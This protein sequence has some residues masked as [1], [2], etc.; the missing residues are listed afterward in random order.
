MSGLHIDLYLESLAQF[1]ERRNRMVKSAKDSA[2]LSMQSL[3]AL[4]LVR[5]LEH[6]LR[7]K[8]HP[9][10]I[11]LAAQDDLWL[12][13]MRALSWRLG[14]RAS[15]NAGATGT[16][17]GAGRPNRWGSGWIVALESVYDLENCTRDTELTRQKAMVVETILE[18]GRLHGR[19]V[20]SVLG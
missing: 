7:H 20:S 15:S 6:L 18:T 9:S 4:C 14:R 17:A 12:A 10:S 3:W 19:D 2:N 16:R 5:W 13:T 8:D 1:C 11:L